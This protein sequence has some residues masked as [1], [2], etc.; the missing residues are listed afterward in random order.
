MK[1]TNKIL[2]VALAVSMLGLSFPNTDYSSLFSS[3]VAVAEEETHTVTIGNDTFEYI[4]EESDSPQ[5]RIIN[6]IGGNRF[7][8][9]PEKIDNIDVVDVSWGYYPY[10]YSEGDPTESDYMNI[11]SLTLPD[12]IESVDGFYA[13]LMQICGSKNGRVLEI[14]KELGVSFVEIPGSDLDYLQYET[15]DGH[16]RVTGI[17]FRPSV[18]DYVIPASIDGLTVADVSLTDCFA[19][20]EYDIMPEE[21]SLTFMNA[22]MNIS[23]SDLYRPST[24]YGYPGSSAQIYAYN[25]NINYVPIS[26]GQNYNGFSFTKYN[27]HAEVRINSDEKELVIPD[28]WHGLPVTVL[29]P[30]ADARN[31]KSLTIPSSIESFGEPGE[32]DNHNR[33]YWSFPAL[34]TVYGNSDFA[35]I[36]VNT[37][38]DNSYDKGVTLSDISTSSSADDFEYEII[39]YDEG[40]EPYVRIWNLGNICNNPDIVIPDTIEGKP[41][42]SIHI[43]CYEQYKLNS[44]TLPDCV[45]E[46]YIDSDIMSDCCI[47]ANYGTYGIEYAKENNYNY[48]FIGLPDEAYFWYRVEDERNEHNYNSVEEY[49]IVCD[50][51]A[52]FN[53]ITIPSEM[54]DLPVRTIDIYQEAYYNEY[55]NSEYGKRNILPSIITIPASVETISIRYPDDISLIRG[56]KGSCAEEYANNYNIRFEALDGDV[57]PDGLR[58]A[59]YED[60]AEI[61]SWPYVVGWDDGDPPPPYTIPSYIKGKRV[62][63]IHAGAFSPIHP[64]MDGI[65]EIVIPDTVTDIDNDF[66]VGHTTDSYGNTSSNVQLIIMGSTGS[67]AEEYANEHN[68]DFEAIEEQTETNEEQTEPDSEFRWDEYN[69]SEEQY[70]CINGFRDEEYVPNGTIIIPEEIDGLPVRELRMKFK[71]TPVSLFIPESVQQIDFSFYFPHSNGEWA[72]E[73]TQSEPKRFISEITGYFG[74]Y[75]QQYAQENNIKFSPVNNY[76]YNTAYLFLTEGYLYGNQSIRLTC[77]RNVIN[78]VIPESVNG[79]EISSISFDR[80]NILKSITF[81]GKTV[82]IAPYCEWNFKEDFPNLEVIKGYK[83]STAETFASEND[84]PF[85]ALPEEGSYQDELTFDFID[86]SYYNNTTYHAILTECDISAVDVVIPE[87][88][89]EYSDSTLYVN[90]TEINANAFKGCTAINSITIPDT[91]TQLPENVFADCINLKEIY[92]GEG[93][94]AEAYAIAHNINFIASQSSPRYI[95]Y[96]EERDHNYEIID[97][98]YYITGENEETTYAIINAYDNKAKSIDIP[99]TINGIAVKE[100]S[101]YAFKGWSNSTSYVVP[102]FIKRISNNTFTDSSIESVTLP[103]NMESIPEVDVHN[104]TVLNPNAEFP[105]YMSTY[106]KLTGFFGSTAYDYAKENNCYFKAILDESDIPPEYLSYEIINHDENQYD[107]YFT[108]IYVRIT[109]IDDSVT[110]AVIP[111][112]IKGI[113]VTR[114]SSDALYG[115]SDLKKLTFSSDYTRIQSYVSNSLK[116]VYGYTSETITHENE[117]SSYI[118]QMELAKANYAVFVDVDDPVLFPEDIYISVYDDEVRIH[119]YSYDGTSWEVPATLYGLP[120]TSVDIESDTLKELTLPESVKYISISSCP[121]I[122]AVTIPNPDCDISVSSDSIPIFH[123]P[124]CSKA[125]ELAVESRSVFYDLDGTEYISPEY[126]EFYVTDDN[127]IAISGCDETVTDVIIPENIYGVPV[128]TIEKYAFYYGPTSVSIPAGVE[129]IWYDA[130]SDK[131]IIYGYTGSRAETYADENGIE[132]VDIELAEHSWDRMEWHWEDFVENEEVFAELKSTDDPDYSRLIKATVKKADGS[133]TPDCTN[134]GSITYIATVNIG[135]TVYSDEY[136]EITSALGHRYS[137]KDIDWQWSEDYSAC[138]AVVSCIECGEYFTMIAAV[139]HEAHQATCTE[140]GY[141][142]YIAVITLNGVEKSDIQ[143]ISIP[144][145]GHSYGELIWNWSGNRTSCTVSRSCTDCGYTQ[146]LTATVTHDYLAPTCTS[147]GH[148]NYIASVTVDGVVRTNTNELILDELSHNK[149]VDRWIWSADRTSCE[150]ELKCRTCSSIIETVQAT[151]RHETLAPTCDEDGYDNYIAE[152]TIGGQ[153]YSNA[154]NQTIYAEGH[155]CY[156]DSWTWS[157]DNSECTLILKCHNCDTVIGDLNANVTSEIT[158]APTYS[159][160]GTVLYTAEFH[161]GTAVFNRVDATFST[162][163]EVEVPMLLR[164]DIASAKVTITETTLDYDGTEK[165]ADVSAVIVNGKTL[166]AGVDYLVSGNTGTDSGDY[167]LTITGIGAYKG[168]VR[169][170][171]RI[172]RKFSVSYTSNDSDNKKTYIYTENAFC[173][174]KATE[175]EGKTFS[176]W[177]LAGSDTILSY[178]ESYIFR[179]VSNTALEAVYV[180]NGE[181]VEKKPVIAITSVRGTNNRIYFEITHDIPDDYTVIQNG[182]LY[183]KNGA[184]D[185]YDGDALDTALKFLNDD[186]D[187]LNE[188]SAAASSVNTNK[189]YYSYY[190]DMSGNND[191]RVC[192]RGYIVV[193]DSDGNTE[194]YYSGITNTSYNQLIS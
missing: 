39:D 42:K 121:N 90:V 112:T 73:Y 6:Y 77:R 87:T 169:R 130:I 110:E 27:D 187:T 79:I 56:Y 35:Q 4:I 15:V 147:K 53:E 48:R 49:V 178:N 160:A 150:V 113:P 8:T 170:Y 159:E 96:S 103:A 153:T 141:D 144:A 28:T 171:W 107:N 68:I 184:F 115:K 174:A 22:G 89:K 126:L 34:E 168:T 98:E 173:K 24:I 162:T 190:V 128:T 188:V 20:Y 161:C 114:V 158:K 33:L 99:E 165:T 5:I 194:I 25:N 93:S 29:S 30:Y 52:N 23:I 179:V 136:T 13:P 164:T 102:D 166:T 84:I 177:K 40:T 12:T 139:T 1:K 117:A 64:G 148:D 57:L 176:H 183:N 152:V 21:Y 63:R 31:L 182:V 61:I 111:A 44:L 106:Y 60:H 85:I 14:A 189:G 142:E 65:L 172:V 155:D 192:L 55:G 75:A 59:L 149:V 76:N 94:A 51:F 175:V 125:W 26:D 181:V 105:E 186:G 193:E 92:G 66:F 71:Y 185:S 7:V 3:L 104:L 18:K 54:Y 43:Y 16:I 50:C 140:E 83:G 69:D 122:E 9:I 11:V 37:W 116:V 95:V 146:N 67:Y 124:L 167:N 101:D 156:V 91:I 154:N 72:S 88:V 133:T 134:D 41:V 19:C 132:F 10:N 62:T 120:I 80:S 108:D 138:N 191:Q 163:K 135:G 58:Y 119:I 2:A 137:T 118:S 46:I 47:Y 143:T 38:N 157:D 123:A 100:L 145:N 74:S 127:T 129:E 86:G 180:D 131:T 70:I 81:L 17:N 109:D 45:E 97:G 32:W 78:A 36:F 151:V 82:D